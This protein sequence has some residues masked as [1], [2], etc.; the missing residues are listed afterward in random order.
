[1]TPMIRGL[2]NELRITFFRWGSSFVNSAELNI[3]KLF[4]C[5]LIN[6]R[7]FLIRWHKGSFSYFSNSWLSESISVI[8]IYESAGETN[9]LKEL[10][11]G[12]VDYLEEVGKDKAKSDVLG[13]ISF[14]YYFDISRS[15]F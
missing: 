5:S 8:C 1:M 3:K 11:E 2:R 12:G 7:F 9:F 6:S 14:V 15:L 10:S 13:S 4:L